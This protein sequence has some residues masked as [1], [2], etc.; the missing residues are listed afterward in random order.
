M[1]AKATG[2]LQGGGGGSRSVNCNGTTGTLQWNSSYT[3]EFSGTVDPASGA[4]NLNGTMHVHQSMSA[5]NCKDGNGKSISCTTPGYAPAPSYPIH[6]LGSINTNGGGGSG[7]LVMDS[8]CSTA[9]TWG[10]GF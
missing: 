2:T 3:A 8:G 9:G 10:S 4:L 1:V 5:N 6:V 7:T